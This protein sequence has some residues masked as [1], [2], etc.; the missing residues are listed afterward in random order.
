MDGE[1]K[2]GSWPTLIGLLLDAVSDVELMGSSLQLC[3]R[4]A[5]ALWG[6]RYPVSL[7][8]DAVGVVVGL[9]AGIVKVGEEELQHPLVGSEGGRG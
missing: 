5:L 6:Q 4:D 8:P 7:P 1:R 9:L 3:Q 2:D